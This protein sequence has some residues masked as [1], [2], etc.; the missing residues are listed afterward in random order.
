MTTD[1]KNTPRSLRTP[2]AIAERLSKINE[3]HV[4]E[5]TN[6]IRQLRQRFPDSWEFPD[7]DPYD[8]GQDAD[9]L[10]LM[11]KPGP[12][13]SAKGGNGSGFISR[14]N[15]DPTAAA[16]FDF[17]V[18]AGIPRNRTVLWNTVPGWN[19]TIAL[20][21]LERRNGLAELPA[22]I[23][24]LPRLKGV[25]LVGR[26]AQRATKKIQ[27]LNLSVFPSSHP[28]PKVRSINPHLWNDIPFR[29]ASAFEAIT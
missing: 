24:L 21:G 5:L 20:K 16:I 28:S 17:M 2:E 27:E 18:Q 25:V 9:L 14:N 11:E 8:G 6:Y 19:K 15:D 22:L 10:F 12:M 1:Y 3:P 26:Q 23:S 4:A 29:W 13:T 7:F